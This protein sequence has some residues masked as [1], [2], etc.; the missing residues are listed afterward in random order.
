MN[1]SLTT[2]ST[3]SRATK[4]TFTSVALFF[5]LS[6]MAAAADCPCF[7]IE[8]ILQECNK[9]NV[10]SVIY[11][12]YEADV[13]KRDP[14]GLYI[15]EFY[16][17][18]CGPKGSSTYIAARPKRCG[19]TSFARQTNVSGEAANGAACT[20]NILEAARQIGIPVEERFDLH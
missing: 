11:Q 2:A 13:Y 16:K 5:G 9:D 1:P 3:I 10:S 6:G 18:Q 8:D 15:D 4:V 20:A 12:K 14:N 17:L 7:T 19:F